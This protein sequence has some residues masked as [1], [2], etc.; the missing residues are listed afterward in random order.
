MTPHQKIVAIK[1]YLQSQ[2]IE[3]DEMIDL[4]LLAFI[5]K[6][7]ALTLGPPG[8]AKSQLICELS[9]CLNRTYFSWLMSK[10]TTPEELF[11]PYS[12]RE[13]KNDRYVR[14]T[15]GKLPQA[16]IA[17]LDEVGK[18]GSLI[19][20][21]LLR[22][23][24]E[25]TFDDGTGEKPIPLEC[26]LGA[27]NE[28]LDEAEAQ[29]FYDRFLFRHTTQPISDSKFILYL[30][31]LAKKIKTQAPTIEDNEIQ[32]LRQ[33]TQSV[34]IP[35][36]IYETITKIKR[37]LAK[38]GINPSDRRWGKS[39]AVIQ[40]NATLQGRTTAIEEDCIPLEHILWINPADHKVVKST[41][42]EFTF[43][44]ITKALEI[45]DEATQLYETY[46]NDVAR[47][48]DENAKTQVFLTTARKMNTYVKKLIPIVQQSNQNS[49]VLRIQ[50]QIT[51]YVEEISAQ[52]LGAMA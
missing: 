44:L 25:H 18:S 3:R 2:F 38:E 13:L 24:N 42:L 10:T 9:K 21:T 47:T 17:F 27:S 16:Q 20:N 22:V 51:S 14:I 30:N 29:A 40:G 41:I 33:N 11:G 36:N 4:L 15:T 7:N 26:L 43:P 45:K 28:M 6:E 5:T 35:D 32:E 52:A 49:E 39:L 34:I 8:T 37:K 19:Q 23:M 31:L 50:A 48:T 46:R 12:I 1:E